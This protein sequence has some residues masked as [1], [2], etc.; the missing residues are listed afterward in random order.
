MIF[1]SEQRFSCESD[2]KMD[3][4]RQKHAKLGFTTLY[5]DVTRNVS[6]Q[7]KCSTYAITKKIK[8]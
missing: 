7:R 2:A 4:K 5:V 8:F 1:F 3:D 6:N